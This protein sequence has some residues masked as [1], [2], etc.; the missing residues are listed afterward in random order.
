M[1]N[2]FERKFAKWWTSWARM[3]P[4][5]FGG[6]KSGLILPKIGNVRFLPHFWERQG[7]L[8]LQERKTK[9]VLNQPGKSLMSIVQRKREYGRKAYRQIVKSFGVECC[10]LLQKYNNPTI[11]QS[12]SKPKNPGY[13][14]TNQPIT[15]KLFC[16][17]HNYFVIST[18]VITVE[19]VWSHPSIR[20]SYSIRLSKPIIS[21]PPNP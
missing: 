7:P 17:V 18:A 3:V 11:K 2:G 21:K 9:E 15:N 1:L 4:N 5:N 10:C 14:R 12:N 13:Y 6:K 19:G 16:I 8:Y 20:P